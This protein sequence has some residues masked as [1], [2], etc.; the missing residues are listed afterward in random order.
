MNPLIKIY[1][2]ITGWKTNTY[3]KWVRKQ[4]R[5]FGEGSTIQKI[6]NLS[7][8]ERI[9]IGSNVYVG[10]HSVLEAITLLETDGVITTDLLRR[11]SLTP[12]Y[13]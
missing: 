5:S 4:F 9:S 2:S 6:E 3:Q 13:V 10:N 1:R 12:T 8:P 11:C 7:H